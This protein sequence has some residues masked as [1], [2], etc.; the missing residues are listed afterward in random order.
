[1]KDN[2]VR[3]LYPNAVT[4]SETENGELTVIDDEGNDIEIDDSLVS[5]ETDRLQAEYDSQDYARSRARAYPSLQ[6]QADMQ[7]HDA[8]DGTTTWQNAIKA[9]KDKYP[10]N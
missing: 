7:Y 6:D 9:V 5:T 8:V 10:K 3:N 1:M 2:A 4:I